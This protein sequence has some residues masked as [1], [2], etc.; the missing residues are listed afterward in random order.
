[1]NLRT[2]LPA[3]AAG[4]LVGLVAVPLASRANGNSDI[5]RRSW[6]NTLNS[7]LKAGIDYDAVKTNP[8]T[9][10]LF[11]VADAACLNQAAALGLARSVMAP[12]QARYAVQRFDERYCVVKHQ[13]QSS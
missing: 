6:I 9:M 13:N 11:G 8:L 12:S 2:M 10:A 4:L 7:E 5:A 3:A 1:M